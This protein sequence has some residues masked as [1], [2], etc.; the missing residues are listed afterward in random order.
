MAGNSCCQV[1]DLSSLISFNYLG[2]LDHKGTEHNLFKNGPEALQK[3]VGSTCVGTNNSPYRVLEIN[4]SVRNGKLGF[5]WE[6]VKDI[7]SQESIL[8]FSNYFVSNLKTLA[9]ISNKP[10]V[11]GDAKTIP[12]MG[13][14]PSDFPTASAYITQAQLDAEFGS[15]LSVSGDFEVETI[16]P[17]TPLQEGMLFDTL[18]EPHSE[19]YM[20]QL[21]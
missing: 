1:L 4:G 7:L 15:K 10:R 12:I 3:I 8:E 16:L 9:E 21:V 18:R 5:S 6:F 13:I 14:S 19:L 11:E 20:T 17:L 2:Q